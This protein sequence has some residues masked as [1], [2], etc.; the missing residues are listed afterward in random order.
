MLTRIL[1]TSSY[2]KIHISQSVFCLFS[3]LWTHCLRT[4]S[5][6]F[7]HFFYLH[8]WSS[9]EWSWAAPTFR[10][11][12]TSC[13][14][15]QIQV[16]FHA[17]IFLLLPFSLRIKSFVSIGCRLQFKRHRQRYMRVHATYM[18][19]HWTR[20]QCKDYVYAVTGPLRI[21]V[22]G[23]SSVHWFLHPFIHPLSDRPILPSD[24]NYVFAASVACPR[25]LHQSLHPSCRPFVHT[26]IYL[27]SFHLSIDFSIRP[28][29]HSAFRP[30]AHSSIWS[31]VHMYPPVHPSASFIFPHFQ[32]SDN[33]YIFTHESVLSILGP[34]QWALPAHVVGLL[35]FCLFPSVANKTQPFT[36]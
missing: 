12:T 5:K 2:C 34:S 1:S 35:Y 28:F 33:L 4:L 29:I 32:P 16:S 36:M 24:H 8:H 11:R 7:T 20:F 3:L 14:H 25:F 19:E 27:L 22:F 23:H 26:S 10:R 15:L 30:T 18:Y 17:V 6:P 31:A 21:S 13:I 9:S